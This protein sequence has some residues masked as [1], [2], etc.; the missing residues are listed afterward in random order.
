VSNFVGGQLFVPWGQIEPVTEG[1]YSWTLIDAEIAKLA[2]AG[3]KAMI[4]VWAHR[5]TSSALPSTPQSGDRYFP[6]YMISAGDAVL[7]SYV[8][9]ACL[10]RESVMDSYMALFA[11]MAARYDNDDR[12]AGIK[13]AETSFVNPGG[14]FTA[15]GLRT[16]FVRLAEYLPTIFTRTPVSVEANY[17]TTQTDIQTLMQACVDAG[18]GMGG[19]DMFPVEFSGS[20]D[21]WGQRALRGE[22]YISSAWVPGSAANQ[23]SEIPVMMEQQVVRSTSATP[24]MYYNAAVSRYSSTHVTWQA[25]TTAV[26]YGSGGA[27]TVPAM[28]WSNVLAYVRDN[29]LP[30]RTSVPTALT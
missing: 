17:L 20:T 16:Q 15:A 30:L 22:R 24:A 10:W 29:A 9:E 23:Q 7:A 5:Y 4:A 14:D 25:K 21:N 19:P 6:D 28:N 8:Q 26:L 2:A 3:K 13:T 1:T 12:V 18:A 27:T 11:A